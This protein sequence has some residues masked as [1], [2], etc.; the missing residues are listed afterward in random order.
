MFGRPKRPKFTL[1]FPYEAASLSTLK[2]E[3]LTLLLGFVLILIS[4]LI[5]R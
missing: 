5:K 2:I 1:Q 4:G 3:L